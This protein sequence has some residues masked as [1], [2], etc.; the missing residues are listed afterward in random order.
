MSL[1]ERLE[2]TWI[3]TNS[4]I[5]KSER[6]QRRILTN[7]CFLCFWLILDDLSLFS[8]P[9]PWSYRTLMKVLLQPLIYYL[10]SPL[11]L[12]PAALLK[13]KLTISFSNFQEEVCETIKLDF[14][15][16]TLLIHVVWGKGL[17][18]RWSTNILLLREKVFVFYSTNK[19]VFPYSDNIYWNFPIQHFLLACN[20]KIIILDCF[21][22]KHFTSSLLEALQLSR[23]IEFVR[24]TKQTLLSKSGHSAFFCSEF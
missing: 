21:F 6:K 7:F 10:S 23:R 18:E 2:L 8:F 4:D 5:N 9:L 16:F 20:L 12:W 13:R 24:I 22:M 1:I 19:N 11:G 3:P 14:I 15:P 17:V